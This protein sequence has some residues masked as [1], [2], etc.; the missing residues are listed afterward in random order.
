MRPS[1]SASGTV[2][3]PTAQLQRRVKPPLG[4]VAINDVEKLV[5]V[6]HES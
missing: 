3:T 5:L 2:S 4:F 1:A 6:R